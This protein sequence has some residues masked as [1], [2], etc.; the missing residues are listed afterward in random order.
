MDTGS[1]GDGALTAETDG[2][3][4][5]LV[6]TDVAEEQKGSYTVSFTP[7]EIGEYR[8][9][10]YWNNKQIQGSPFVVWVCMTF[11]LN[12]KVLCLRYGT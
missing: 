9:K 1:S 5:N 11:F 6:A 8:T 10:V 3:S 12:L 4:R 2:P 7:A